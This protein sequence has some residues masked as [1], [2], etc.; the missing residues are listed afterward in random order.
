[1]K[2]IRVSGI[3][4]SLVALLLVAMAPPAS[5]CTPVGSSAKLKGNYSFRLSP[6]KGFDADLANASDPGNVTG[7]PRQNVLMTGMFTSDGCGDITAMDVFATT[8]TKTGDTWLIG[9]TGTGTYTVSADLT[10]TLTLTPVEA[11]FTPSVTPPVACSPGVSPCCTDETAAAACSDT[12]YTGTEEGTQ[13][14]SISI[15]TTN[16]RVEL[17]E[18][19]NTGGGAKIFMVGEAIKQ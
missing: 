11:A 1:M 4:L 17:S 3:A 5:A 16:G 14:Y 15:S 12:V 8:D 7:A 2:T 18:T 13:T 10:G 6:A 19:D 9:F